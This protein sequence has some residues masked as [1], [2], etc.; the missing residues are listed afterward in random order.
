MR[1]LRTT[2]GKFINAA[3]IVR[4][5][6][7][8]DGT[9]WLAVLVDGGEVPL[10]PY[11]SAPGRVERDFPHLVRGPATAAVARPAMAVC[12]AEACCAQ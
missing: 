1:L 10:A 11:Y 4:L 2:A 6:R 9:G 7:E 12:Q 3:A 8:D 5:H